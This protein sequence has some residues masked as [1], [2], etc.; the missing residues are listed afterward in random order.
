MNHLQWMCFFLSPQVAMCQHCRTFGGRA[1]FT[2]LKCFC[3]SLISSDNVS[4]RSQAPWMYTQTPAIQEL[5]NPGRLQQHFSSLAHCQFQTSIPHI[6]LLLHWTEG[7]GCEQE[8]AG[9][10]DLC[11]ALRT[12]GVNSGRISPVS[13]IL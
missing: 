1:V 3:K 8:G 12:L 9:T 5:H 10:S 7:E 11:R 2:S 4:A 6:P 13:C